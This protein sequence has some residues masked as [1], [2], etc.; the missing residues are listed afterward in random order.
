MTTLVL[1]P[2]EWGRESARV[3]G[4][5]YRHLFRARR[6]AV[7][8]RLKVVDGSGRARWA[9]VA[10]VGR[11]GARLR[12]GSDAPS[13]EP[14]RPVELFVAMPRAS[15]A[16]WMVEKATEIGACAI[17]FVTFERSARSLGAGGLAR[18]ERVARA[19]V[20][21][22]GRALQP[23]LAGELSWTDLRERLERLE[24]WLY[25]DLGAPR[26]PVRP[27]GGVGLVV[28]PEGGLTEAERADLASWGGVA[29]GLGQRALR[30]ETAAVAATVLAVAS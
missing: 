17:T 8:E 16:A 10:E 18:L 5:A 9:E 15:R 20:E 25:L 6:L 28:G 13:V 19:A 30:V 26:A 27:E 14:A 12:L 22:C 29:L 3:E 24:H 23:R 7:G 2:E 11:D 4:D 21:Q 1:S